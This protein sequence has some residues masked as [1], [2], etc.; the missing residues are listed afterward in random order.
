MEELVEQFG[1]LKVKPTT[2]D[3]FDKMKVVDLKQYAKDHKIS[4][5]SKYTKKKD[6]IEFMMSTM[7][8]L[9]PK[10][11]LSPKKKPLVTNIKSY[12]GPFNQPQKYGVIKE[13][14]KGEYGVVYQVIQ[15][16]EN[17]MYAL[18]L[19]N[20][21]KKDEKYW[22]KEVQC[23]K[24][25]YQ[26]CDKVGLLCFKEE[27][28]WNNKLVIVTDLLEGY[29][30]LMEYIYKNKLTKA[31]IEK[32]YSQV[33]H[34]KNALTILCINH[35]DLHTRNIMIDPTTLEIKVID[36]GRCQTPE[37]EEAEWGIGTYDW[38]LYS[39]EARLKELRKYLAESYKNIMNIDQNDFMSKLE[40]K[41][42]V[43][44]YKKG[45]KR[46]HL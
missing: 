44:P 25:I 36:L 6:L 26:I 2:F 38:N 3:D 39:D 35:S 33:I 43:L 37:E 9:S 31:Q 11:Q 1:N 22:I 24:D 4:G 8:P 18:K 16:E 34:I 30:D 10:K 32:I 41:F 13:L 23:L 45:C 17:K 28:V 5:Y 19:F 42:P 14:G 7:K 40:L 12:I 15:P 27:F 21:I 20:N 46:I 29:Q